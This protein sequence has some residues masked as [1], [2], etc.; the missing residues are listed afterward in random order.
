MSSR[1]LVRL[2]GP[3]AMLGGVLWVTVVTGHTF[4]HGSTQSPRG[5]TL[6]GLE[7][8]DF[9]R[10]LAIPPLLFAVG[11]AGARA[12]RATRGTSGGRLGRAGFVVA[13]LGLALVALGVIL[14]T[15]IVDPSEDFS[16]PLVQGG[17]IAY[18]LGLF[19]VLPL[20]M[21]LFGVGSPHMPRH[22]RLLAIVI[23]VLAPLQWLEGVLSS[24]SSGSLTWDLVYSV[25]RG[26][27]GV[28]WIALGYALWRD[29]GERHAADARGG[30]RGREAG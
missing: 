21:L 19:P 30:G 12:S 18:L 28:G 8:L 15:W 2:A 7:S 10:L 22:V 3:A 29:G 9:F 27:L 16:H 26:L 6:L 11:L 20:G 23:G 13:L 4:T 14:E 5:A 24:V 1:T 17:W 25:L